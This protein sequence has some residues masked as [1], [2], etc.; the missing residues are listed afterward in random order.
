LCNVGRIQ[1][2]GRRLG[3]S[4]IASF[5]GEFWGMKDSLTRIALKLSG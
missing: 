2:N 5:H 3:T 4:M 1:G